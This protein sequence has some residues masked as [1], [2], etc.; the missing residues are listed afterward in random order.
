MGRLENKSSSWGAS[1]SFP[2]RLA[3][4]RIGVVSTFTETTSNITVAVEPTPLVEESNP[5]EGAFVFAYSIRIRNDS[6]SWV[7]LLERHW[8]IE[9]AGEQINEVQGSGVVGV[10]PIIEPGKSFEY[11]SSTVIKD[12]VGAMWGSYVFKRGSGG[13]FT[14][15]IPRFVLVYPVLVN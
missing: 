6:D 9:S 12:P 3:L 10:Q 1:W 4:D 14:V 11:T 8:L 2:V 7:Q 15:Q 13:F 5:I